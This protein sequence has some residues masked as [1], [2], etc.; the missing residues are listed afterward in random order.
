MI[1]SAPRTDTTRVGA[2][3]AVLLAAG[4]TVGFVAGQAA[5]DIASSLFGAASVTT[6]PALTQSA[7]Y[8]VRHLSVTEALTPADDYGVRL[9]T[10]P[11]L[12][13]VDDYGI[14]HLS[15]APLTPA[16]DYGIRHQDQP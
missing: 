10:A 8:G 5:P 15:T 2:I 9:L 11:P 13:P 1:Q 4:M 7:D 16:D 14:R 6:A 12:T 3:A